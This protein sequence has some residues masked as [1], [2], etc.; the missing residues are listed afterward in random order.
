M[1]LGFLRLPFEERRVYFD[2]AAQQRDLS[3]VTIEKDFWVCW[4]LGALFGS[5]FGDAL[6][7]KGG[8]SL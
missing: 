7:F 1:R 5:R 8:T 4:L 3:P 6:V 2:Q